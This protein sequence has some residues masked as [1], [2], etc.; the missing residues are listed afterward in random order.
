VLIVCEYC[1]AAWR[2][3]LQALAVAASDSAPAVVRQAL[4][5]LRP[6]T[7][8]LFRR[9]GHTHFAEAVAAAAAA[10]RNPVSEELGVSAVWALQAVAK[11]LADASPEVWTGKKQ[12]YTSHYL[13]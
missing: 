11:R 5:A 12:T 3:V 10:M 6:V 2:S 7:D 4:E 1:R 13:P 8:A 9:G